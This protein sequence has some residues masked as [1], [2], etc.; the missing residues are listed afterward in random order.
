MTALSLW[1]RLEQRT[2][3]LSPLPPTGSV[4]NDVGSCRTSSRQK[5][6]AAMESDSHS[7]SLPTVMGGLVSVRDRLDARP[8]LG[9]PRRRWGLDQRSPIWDVIPVA[10]SVAVS[11]LIIIRSATTLAGQRTYLLFDDAAISLTYARN[12]ANGHGLVWNVGH[13]PVEGYSNFL[14]TLWMAAIE[15]TRPSESLA[16]LWVMLTGVLLLAANTYVIAR[17]ARRLAPASTAAPLLAGL[18]TALYF[19][20]IT[21]TLSGM[22]TGLVA[23]LSSSAVLCALRACDTVTAPASEPSFS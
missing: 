5:S 18:A 15:T 21:W 23:V 22:E 3:H 17:I 8:S 6:G 7:C 10:V 9:V 2:C 12:L 20:L 19:G 16:G 1:S 11:A 4:S 14:W 13:V